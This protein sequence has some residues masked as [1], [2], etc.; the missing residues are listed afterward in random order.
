MSKKEWEEW[1]HE[2]TREAMTELVSTPEF[3]EW[4]IEHADRI[5]IRPRDSSDDE[6]GSGSDS[7]DETVVE[8]GPGLGFLNW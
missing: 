4:L 6:A 5:Q 8:N 3:S 1:T 7:T 2:S